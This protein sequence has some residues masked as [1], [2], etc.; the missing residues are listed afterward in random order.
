LQAATEDQVAR[1]ATHAFSTSF[2]V[3]AL[4]ALLALI[5]AALTRGR[6]EL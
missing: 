6:F 1:A 4:I 2:A 3:A 5:P